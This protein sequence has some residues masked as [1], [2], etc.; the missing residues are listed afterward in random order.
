MG[1][2]P[3]HSADL[4]NIPGRKQTIAKLLATNQ[5]DND[6]LHQD[7][8]PP[9]PPL[10]R[11]KPNMYKVSPPSDILSRVQAF[12]PQLQTANSELDQKDPSE[13]DIENV[14]EEQEGQYIEMNL[15]LGV[16]EAKRKGDASD[17]SDDHDSDDNDEIIIPSSSSKPT[18][19]EKPNIQLLHSE[20]SNDDKHS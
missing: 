1:D 20:D 16:F 13:L 6:Q 10:P 4:L 2:S 12:L 14:N 7:T 8:A 15:G 18:T 3:K 9:A 5:P 11:Q 19:T 17:T